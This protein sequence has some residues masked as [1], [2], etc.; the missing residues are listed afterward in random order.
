MQGRGL[1]V[2]SDVYLETKGSGLVAH[3]SGLEVQDSKLGAQDRRLRVDGSGFRVK[4]FGQRRV[5]GSGSKVLSEACLR[6]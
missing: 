4:R 5:D 1:R 6:R 3:N 2:Q